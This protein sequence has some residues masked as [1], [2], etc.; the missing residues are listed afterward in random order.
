MRTSWP[1]ER[2]DRELAIRNPEREEN[3]A[4]SEHTPAARAVLNRVLAVDPLA[5]DEWSRSGRTW[6][7]TR[8][9]SRRAF[10]AVANRKGSR[11]WRIAVGVVAVVLLAAVAVGVVANGSDSRS[12]TAP[13]GRMHTEWRLV[14]STGPAS[15]FA[16]TQT[17][18]GLIQ[19]LTCPT[20]SVCYEVVDGGLLG[21]TL[22][23]GGIQ[24]GIPLPPAAYESND[25]G[26]TWRQLTL[27]ADVALT[28]SFTCPTATDCMVGATSG[29]YGDPGAPAVLLSTQDAGATWTATT[30]PL[31]GVITGTDPALDPEVTGQP[32]YL[33]QLIC[34]STQTCFGFG[35]VPTDQDEQPLTATPALPVSLTVFVRTDDGG[36]TW[37]TYAFPWMAN[38]DGSPGWSNEEPATFSCATQTSCIGVAQVLSG[39]D[40]SGSGVQIPSLFTWSTTNGGTTWSQ[41]WIAGMDGVQNGLSCP[42]ADECLATVSLGGLG[43]SNDRQ[44]GVLVTT[45][46]GATWAFHQLS[47]GYG[48]M[49]PVSCLKTNDCWVGGSGATTASTAAIFATF[50]GG[51]TWSP[52]QLPPALTG[53]TTIDCVSTVCLAIARPSSATPT[54]NG[55]VWIV[56]SVVLT[57]G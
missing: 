16:A 5:V 30:V 17:S 2:I 20:T 38:P 42:S 52:V 27:P 12:T 3:L 1:D 23:Q 24:G 57:N 26:V 28:T 37:T 43:S 46:G 51:T 41:S 22:V 54:L 25:G 13:V 49:G 45:D 50:D 33:N 9:D 4:G 10:R 14:S 11:K 53:I 15:P 29:P 36:A 56:P 55:Q 31:T 18:A 47:S 48:Y 6:A 34:F 19:S 35:V 40:P 21:G 32:G 8:Q 44:Q 39:P 7:W